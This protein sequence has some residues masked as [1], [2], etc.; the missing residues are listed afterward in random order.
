MKKIIFLNSQCAEYD[1]VKKIRTEVFTNEQGADAQGEFDCYD[2]SAEYA[3]LFDDNTAIAT[4]RLV[5]AESGCKI[6]RIAVLK[7]YRGQ[8]LGDEIVRAVVQRAFNSGTQ[9]VFVDAQNYAVGFYEKIGFKIIGDEITDRG[10]PHIPMCL[11]RS[12][13]AEREE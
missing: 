12:E 9:R 11:E 5:K 13:Y 3:L 4:A 10:L 2:N 7:Q 6:G 8:G 1:L